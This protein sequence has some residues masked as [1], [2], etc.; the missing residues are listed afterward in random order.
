LPR[1]GRIRT[2]RGFAALGERGRRARH[3]ALRLT[4]LLDEDA[5]RPEVAFAIGKAVG[6]AVVRNRLRRR[7]RAAMA[8]LAPP[9]GRYLVA[10][11]PDAK[12]IDYTTLRAQLARCLAEVAA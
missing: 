4:A 2:R 8:E 7:L 5:D 12:G 6:P 10:A 3:G 11:Q 1:I 9:P